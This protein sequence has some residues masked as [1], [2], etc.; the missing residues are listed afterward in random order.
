MKTLKNSDSIICENLETAR[1][2]ASNY[3]NSVIV[4]KENN[5]SVVSQKTYNQLCFFGY[6][7]VV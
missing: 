2:K 5:Y 6:V 3:S 4:V 1:L 7:K